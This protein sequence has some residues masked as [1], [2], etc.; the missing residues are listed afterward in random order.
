MEIK[1]KIRRFLLGKDFFKKLFVSEMAIQDIQSMGMLSSLLPNNKYIPITSYTLS[2]T[3]IAHIINEIVLLQK[4][5][6]VEFGSGLSTL[7]IARLLSYHKLDANIFSIDHDREWHNFLRSSLNEEGIGDNVKL[8][9]ADLESTTCYDN[10]QCKWYAKDIL[11]EALPKEIDLVIVDGPPIQYG[12]HCRYF[13]IPFLLNRLSKNYS[14]FIDDIYRKGENQIL[15]KWKD[16]LGINPV[17]HSRYAVFTTNRNISTLP[18]CL[19]YNYKYKEL[20][21]MTINT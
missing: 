13:A 16:I 18:I 12:K 20:L 7:I 4:K 21:K 6:I 14:V 17:K 9:Q 5:T 10:Q 8:I 3:S 1:K 19:S 11:E 15:H 2:P